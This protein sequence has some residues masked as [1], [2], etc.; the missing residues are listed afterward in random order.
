MQ[1]MD[2]GESPYTVAT[3]KVM[4]NNLITNVYLNTHQLLLHEPKARRKMH[5]SSYVN[6]G[7][8]NVPMYA[9]LYFFNCTM[10]LYYVTEV[11]FIKSAWRVGILFIDDLPA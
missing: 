5:V 3:S 8:S 9:D 1:E 2:E 4:T 7:V 11:G 10:L 6:D